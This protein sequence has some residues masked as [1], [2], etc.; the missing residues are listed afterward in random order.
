M[1]APQGFGDSC[2]R[3]P[4]DREF[5]NH[6]APQHLGFLKPVKVHTSDK[7]GNVAGSLDDVIEVQTVMSNRGA[8]PPGERHRG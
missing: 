8:A 3:F 5:L 4:D 2:G 7:I 6:R 1:A